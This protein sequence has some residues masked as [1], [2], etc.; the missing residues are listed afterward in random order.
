MTQRPKGE[1]GNTLIK[2]LAAEQGNGPTESLLP[3]PVG[4]G[5]IASSSLE[6]GNTRGNATTKKE[7][8]D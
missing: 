8:I 4:P 6:K 5:E 1:P 2:L 3:S 7:M